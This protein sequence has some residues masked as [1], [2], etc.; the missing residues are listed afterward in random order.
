ML[1]TILREDNDSCYKVQIM[2]RVFRSGRYALVFT[3]NLALLQKEY[4]ICR[5][6]K[7][8]FFMLSSRQIWKFKQLLKIL[9]YENNL[10]CRWT[11]R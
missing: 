4:F 8:R 6:F 3:R 9:H 2:I 11:H 7:I 10:T 5:D 1:N